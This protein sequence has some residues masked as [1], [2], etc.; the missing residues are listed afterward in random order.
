MTTTAVLHISFQAGSPCPDSIVKQPCLLRGGSNLGK[1]HS[2][3]SVKAGSS[4]GVTRGCYNRRSIYLLSVK[5][6]GLSPSFSAWV[7]EGCIQ[8]DSMH[9]MILLSVLCGPQQ[10]TGEARKSS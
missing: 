9:A 7:K 1:M 5:K 8:D 6:H 10:M 4:E 2:L 3:T